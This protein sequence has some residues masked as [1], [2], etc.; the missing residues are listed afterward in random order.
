[1]KKPNILFLFTDDQRFDTINSL[2]NS[3]IITPNL[4]KLVKHGTVFTHAHIPSGSCAA[5]CMPSRA[6]LNSG[7][8]LFHIEGCGECIPPEHVTMAEAFR[9]NGYNTFGTGKW[10]NGRESYHR[11][12][13]DGDEI[14]FG[15]MFDHW[16]APGFHFDS[17]GKYDKTIPLIPNP[18]FSNEVIERPADHITPGKHSTD[19]I[20]DTSINF[21]RNSEKEEPFYMYVSFLAPHDPR[22]MPKKYLDMYEGRKI[23]LPENFMGGHSFDNG[24]LYVR[25][26]KLAPFPRNP[27]DTLKQIKEYYAMITHVDDR[28]GDIVK[29]L[30]YKGILDDTIIVLSGDNGLAVGQHGLFGK[31][32]CYEHSTRVPLIFSGPGIPENSK[33]DAYVY[34]FDIFPTLCDLVGME[35]PKSVEGKSFAK[36]INKSEDKFRDKLY[37]GYRCCQRAVKDRHFKLIEYVVDGKNNMTQLFDL[38]NDPLEIKNLAFKEEYKEK[39]EELRSEMFK[40]RDEWD[41]NLENLGKIFWAGFAHNTEK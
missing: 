22:S 20:A 6:M 11:G 27:D 33:T 34:L 8:S 39:V 28:I 40:F 5:V 10:H 24:E 21:I 25:D 16:N 41:D 32:N 30:E 17:S 15:G 18:A 7:R 1:M 2:G 4:D 9:A 35:I 3:K 29:A 19:I 26:E 36:V 13:T 14:W 38:R 31:Q 37:F 12:F 23:T